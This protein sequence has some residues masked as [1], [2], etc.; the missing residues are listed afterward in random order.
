MPYYVGAACCVAGIAILF[1]RRHHLAV[2]DHVDVD[3][4]FQDASPAQA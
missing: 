2:L 3:H 4:T 1:A